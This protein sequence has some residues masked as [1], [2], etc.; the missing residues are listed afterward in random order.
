MVKPRSRHRPSLPA[1]PVIM[2]L[3][4]AAGIG[5]TANLT[6]LASYAPGWSS[7]VRASLPGSGCVI[8][9]NVSINT[10]ERIYHVPGQRYY[11]ETKISPQYGER[12]FC[13]ETEAR[14]SGWRRSR[15]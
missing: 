13:S 11:S 2:L 3:G 14:Q 6:A 7:S 9:G 4:G 8:K 12:W 1:L 10:G 5:Y 15:I